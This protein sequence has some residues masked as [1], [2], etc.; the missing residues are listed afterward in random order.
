MSDLRTSSLDSQRISMDRSLTQSTIFTTST[1]T[2]TTAP[3]KLSLPERL[4]RSRSASRTRSRSNSPDNAKSET[5]SRPVSKRRP[6]SNH[7]RKTSDD[8]RRYNNTVNHYGRHSND[9]LF[10]GFSLRDTVRDG[11]DRLR[12]RSG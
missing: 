7:S 4:F 10:G 6:G 9:W 12:G 2:S 11:V 1:S 5:M 3:Q 8:Y